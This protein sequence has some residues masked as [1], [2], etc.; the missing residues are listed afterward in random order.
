MFKTRRYPCAIVEYADQVVCES[1]VGRQTNGRADGQGERQRVSECPTAWSSGQGSRVTRPGEEWIRAAVLAG[2]GFED[3]CTV[4]DK[5][6]DWGMHPCLFTSMLLRFS[7]GTGCFECVC[8][9]RI[10]E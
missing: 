4:C 8:N 2:L 5:V 7:V 10:V 1:Y 3:W 6:H 9:L